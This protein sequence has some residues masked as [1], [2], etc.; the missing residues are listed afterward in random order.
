VRRR[1]RDVAVDDQHGARPGGGGALLSH[2]LGGPPTPLEECEAERDAAAR[3][4]IRTPRARRPPPTG[5]KAWVR[6]G[7]EG[8]KVGRRGVAVAGWQWQRVEARRTVWSVTMVAGDIVIVR[9]WHVPV[10]V[11]AGRSDSE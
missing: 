3:T 4:A 9:R 8:A 11:D 7:G 10:V 6:D 1:R 2:A 5:R